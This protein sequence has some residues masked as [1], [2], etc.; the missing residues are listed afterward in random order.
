VAE[1]NKMQIQSFKDLPLNTEVQRSIEELG[2]ETLFPIQAQAIIPLLEG[3]D[4]IGQAQTGTGKTAA[5]GL[6]MVQCLNREVRGVQGLVL[7]PTRELAVQVADNL[8]KFGKHSKVKV[9]A[10]YGGESI[11]KQIHSLANGVQIVVGTPGRLIDLMERRVLNLGTIRIVVLD[12]ADRMLDMGFIE[13]IEYILSKTPRERQ[14]S[15]FSATMADSVM[16]LSNKYMKNPQKILV[17]KDEIALTQMKQY[18]TVVNQGGKLGALC[19]ILAD[20][21]VDKAIIFCRTR[22][23]TSRLADQL[24]KKGFRTQVLHAGFTQAQR[25]RAINDFRHG[26]HTLLVATDVAARGLDIEGITHIINYD[27]PNDPPVYFHRIGRTARKGEEGTAITLVS[28]GEMSNFNDIKALTKTKIEQ[29]KA[30]A[31]D[32]TKENDSPIQSFY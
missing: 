15:L 28:Y 13:D 20:D 5:F 3:K 2:Y 14:T 19:E 4:V 27:V 11:N 9:L 30:G 32:N 18:F 8:T 25:D 17:S 22:H 10:V 26:K 6:P 29:L 16:R 7:V 23:E 12:E 1:E 21:R 31:E 24:Y